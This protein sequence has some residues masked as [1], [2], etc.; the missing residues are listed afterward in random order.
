MP[1][2]L[3]TGAS[4][5]IGRAIA[6]RLA[7]EGYD[8]FLTARTVDA[9]A[10]VAAD[11]RDARRLAELFAADLSQEAAAASVAAAFA[12]RFSGLNVLVNNAGSAPSGPFEQFTPGEWDRVM[13]LNAGSPFFLTQALLPLLRQA[14]PG[15]LINI[16]SVVSRK[17][18]PEQTLYSASKHAL[19]GW[20]KALAQE[21]PTEEVRIHAVLPGG[22]D[23]DLVRSVRPDIDTG[24]LI[25][26]E[27]V[28]DV[29]APLV[30]MRGNAMIDQV[31][32]RR[33]TKG[34]FQ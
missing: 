13:R 26:P 31:E 5:G 3:V 17:G 34:A 12:A 28:A 4:R 21:V 20:T 29:V 19:L 30:S 16:G 25:S 32:I 11:V 14:R 23:T 9:L 22:V 6:A 2:A 15:Y 24:E 10:D 7:A 18:Y 1:V 27:E 33:S 8:L